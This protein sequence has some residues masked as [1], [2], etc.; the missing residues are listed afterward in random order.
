MPST[1]RTCSSGRGRTST[2]RPRSSSWSTTP[3]RSTRT[4]ST[5]SPTRARTGSGSP[6]RSPSTP[7]SS[8]RRWRTSR[9][10][11]SSA[12]PRSTTRRSRSIAT[13]A[14]TT[15][16]TNRSPTLIPTRPDQALRTPSSVRLD[17]EVPDTDLHLDFAAAHFGDPRV[18]DWHWPG[19]RGGARSV[20]QV[21]EMLIAHAVGAERDGYT[22]WWWRERSSGDPVG[23][24]GLHPVE[25]E[26]SD[27]VEVGWSIAPERWGEGL[28]VEAA[29]ASI[30]F[31]F[32]NFGLT[33]VVSFTMVN[34]LRSRR[35]MEKLGM[36]P[37]GEIDRYGIPHVLF[38]L[39]APR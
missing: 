21:R 9:P 13:T 11:R 6:T 8:T 33:R 16:P 5:W 18:A 19:S 28:A 36:E 34:N 27:E 29:A 14:P 4:C 23:M 10:A 15:S 12:R 24:V 22:L 37:A 2:R 39:T 26:G 7:T 30:R 17:A 20:E 31:G 3:F 38:R 25:I 1:S 35:V 32:E